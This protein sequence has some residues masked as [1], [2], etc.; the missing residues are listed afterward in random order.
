RSVFAGWS[1][2]TPVDPYMSITDRLAEALL[3]PNARLNTVALQSV[4]SLAPVPDVLQLSQPEGF[5]YYALHPLAFAE[6]L[7][8][9]RGL[10]ARVAV[11][12]IR[13]I[14]VILSAVT[15]AA[16]R[17][18]GLSA[19]RI[20]VRPNGHPYNRTMKFSSLEI[21]FVRQQAKMGA[22]FLVVDEGPGL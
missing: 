15:A 11:I 5:A 1:G 9:L 2:A 21:D 7:A 19:E 22:M 12:G 8:R 16:A 3:V 17:A 10:P 4:L 13:T 6:V 20:T 18:R 14:G